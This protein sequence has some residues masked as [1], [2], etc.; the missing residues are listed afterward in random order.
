MKKILTVLLATVTLAV[1]SF[2]HGHFK[3]PEFK[4]GTEKVY[5]TYKDKSNLPLKLII[6]KT[7]DTNFDVAYVWG[8][9][10]IFIVKTK[11]GY[12]DRNGNFD[13]IKTKKGDLIIKANVTMMDIDKG[14]FFHS[15]YGYLHSHVYPKL[16]ENKIKIEDKDYEVVKFDPVGPYDKS[17]MYKEK[18][19]KFTYLYIPKPMGPGYQIPDMAEFKFTA[20]LHREK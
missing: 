17:V 14:E 6:A 4:E 2:S 11:Y 15:T 12:A 3:R 8:W 5:V 7:K 10:R 13:I 9:G 1:S 20:K 19:G 18:D 16:S